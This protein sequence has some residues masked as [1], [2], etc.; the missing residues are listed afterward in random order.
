MQHAIR[1][2]I[3]RFFPFLASRIMLLQITPKEK[4]VHD[5]P[6][7][8]KLNYALVYYPEREKSA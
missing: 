5:Q 6:L 7:F 1:R 2:L 8:G 3:M 4:K